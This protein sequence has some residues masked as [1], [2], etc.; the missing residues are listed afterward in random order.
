MGNGRDRRR[1]APP[2][3]V[4]VPPRPA[5]ADPY[6]PGHG[7]VTFA[8]RHY[9]LALDYRL[10][11]NALRAVATLTVDALEPIDTLT[12]DLHGLT[13]RKVIVVPDKLVN[14]VVG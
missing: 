7:D 5:D 4:A 3:T 11:T 2:P 6:L 1:S 9:D 14:I 8:V 13:V 12:L 10:T